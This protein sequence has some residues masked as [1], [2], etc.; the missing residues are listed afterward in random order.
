MSSDIRKRSL[1][2]TGV[3]RTDAVTGSTVMD[4]C[5]KRN[6]GNYCKRATRIEARLK[7]W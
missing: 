7:V 4:E 6:C 1:P 2:S 5:R 3:L